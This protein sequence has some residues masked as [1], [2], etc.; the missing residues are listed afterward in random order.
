MWQTHLRRA[1]WQIDLVF[2]V[3]IIYIVVVFILLIDCLKL[4]L[5]KVSIVILE[6]DSRNV[7]S[8]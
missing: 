2:Y 3:F 4:L 5:R 1:Y 6:S 8:Y 7:F